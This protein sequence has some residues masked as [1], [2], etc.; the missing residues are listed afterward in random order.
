[1]SDLDHNRARST[2]RAMGFVNDRNGQVATLKKRLGE[3]RRHDV[4]K[5]THNA[6]TEITALRAEVE[7]LRGLMKRAY[8]GG[9]DASA[10]GY[11]GEYPFQDNNRKPQSDPDFCADM[12]QFLAA[13]APSQNDKG[14]G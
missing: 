6:T 14:D 1:M 7:R 10:E 9:F 3:Y 2:W 4:I 5:A 11:N 8:I 12:R 13:L